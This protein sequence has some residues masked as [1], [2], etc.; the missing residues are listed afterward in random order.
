MKIFKNLNGEP[1]KLKEAKNNQASYVCV[2]W[3]FFD[4]MLALTQVVTYF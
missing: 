1:W 4:T 2:A 3:T